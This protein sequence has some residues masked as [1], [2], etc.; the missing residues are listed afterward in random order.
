MSSVIGPKLFSFMSI[1]VNF[2][3]KRAKKEKMLKL[4]LKPPFHEIEKSKVKIAVKVI[5][6]FGNDTMKIKETRV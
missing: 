6:I 3:T 5:D 1:Y 4:E 2:W